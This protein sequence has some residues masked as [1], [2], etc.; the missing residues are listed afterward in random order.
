MRRTVREQWLRNEVGFV[1]WCF[2]HLT[3][4]VRSGAKTLQRS[5]DVTQGG[6]NGTYGFV[7]NLRHSTSVVVNP[8]ALQRRRGELVGSDGQTELRV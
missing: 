7:R 4:A 6:V 3:V 5:F 8:F 2:A 1:D